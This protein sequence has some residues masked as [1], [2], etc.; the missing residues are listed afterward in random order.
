MLQIAIVEDDDREAK[1]LN[2]CLNKYAQEHKSVFSIQRFSDGAAFLSDE[3]AVFDLVFMDVEMPFMD[4]LKTAEKLREKDSQTVLVFVTKL[5]QYAV[6]GYE[7]NAAD[8]IIKPIRFASFSLKMEKIEKKCRHDTE[9]YIQLKY[10]GGFRRLPLSALS[11]VELQGH[12]I[13]YH[14]DDGELVYYGNGKQVEETLPPDEFFRCNSGYFVNL[15][16]V[17]GLDGFTVFLGDT[18]LLV[19]HSRKKAFVETLH[20]YFTQRRA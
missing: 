15:Q 19:S 8:Y 16:R 4:G 3:K 1:V 6:N 11:Y 7:Y 10:S 2:D 13:V 9:K 18:E 20:T 5:F 12:R 14:T 17:T